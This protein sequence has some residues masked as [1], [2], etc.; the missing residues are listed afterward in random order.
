MIGF[1]GTFCV[2]DRR[3]ARLTQLTREQCRRR[4]VALISSVIV[5]TDRASVRKATFSCGESI[6][7]SAVAARRI[8]AMTR[9]GNTDRDPREVSARLSLTKEGLDIVVACRVERVP[10]MAPSS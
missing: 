1:G 9:D 10:S 3:V 7:C 5:M 4:R 6:E 2:L 8:S